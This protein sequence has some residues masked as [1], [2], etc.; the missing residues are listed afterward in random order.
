MAGIG[1]A[2]YGAYA[3]ATAV[4]GAIS[5]AWIRGGL[6]ATHVRKAFALTSALGVA[7]TIAGSEIGR[8]HV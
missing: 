4:S 3:V 7:V 2:I 8:A 1:A 5:D 6:S